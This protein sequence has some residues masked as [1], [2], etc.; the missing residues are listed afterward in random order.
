MFIKLPPSVLICLRV[1]IIA[2]FDPCIFHHVMMA[3]ADVITIYLF[4]TCLFQPVFFLNVHLNYCPKMR[5][6]SLQHEDLHLSKEFN[7]RHQ[8]KNYRMLERWRSIECM[9]HSK[10]ICVCII[11]KLN[12]GYCSILFEK[13]KTLN[14]QIESNI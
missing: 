14:F 5:K 6:T 1:I 9:N 3:A 12:F 10:K 7:G 8:R 2:S 4:R 13:K 11:R